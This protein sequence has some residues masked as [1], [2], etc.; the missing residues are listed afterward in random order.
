MLDRDPKNIILIGNPNT[1][2]STLFNSLTGLNQKTGNF[3]GVTVDKKSGSYTY[4]KKHVNII[5][6]PGTYS[7]TPNSEDEKV[8]KNYI[9][10]AHKDDLILVVADATNLKRNLLLY[11][12]IVDQGKQVI[13][14]LNMMDLLQ[15]N[16]QEIDLNEVYQRKEIVKVQI[17]EE[18]Y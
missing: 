1:G 9:E 6:L 4:K 8:S 12:Q 3:P 17:A 13:L 10:S 11:T 5:D 16:K 18:T 15:K 2:K 7:L 14:V